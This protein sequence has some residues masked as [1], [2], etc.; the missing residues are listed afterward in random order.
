MMLRDVVIRYVP[1]RYTVLSHMYLAFQS[2]SSRPLT[3][4]FPVV[5][6]GNANAWGH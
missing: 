3:H 2:F 4:Q 5:I 6:L 1:V